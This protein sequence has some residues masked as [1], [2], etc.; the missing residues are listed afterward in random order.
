MV[1]VKAKRIGNSNPFNG[2]GDSD[3][4]DSGL[5][6]RNTPESNFSRSKTLRVSCCH[7]PR[8]RRSSEN[9]RLSYGNFFDRISDSDCPS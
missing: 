1:T 2:I 7:S 5:P 9:I 3:D 4:S 8:I 6:S